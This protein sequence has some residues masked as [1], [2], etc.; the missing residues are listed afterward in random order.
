MVARSIMRL[1]PPRTITTGS[2]SFKSIELTGLSSVE[3][4]KIWGKDIAMV[5]QNP[6]TSL[7]PVFRIGSQITWTLRHHLG[8]NKD[9]AR[10][11]AVLLLERVGIPDA[12]RR[13]ESYPHE[14]SG[15][16]RQRVCIAIAIA[17]DPV[18]VLADEP[19]TALDVTIQRQILDLLEAISAENEMAMILISHDLGVIASRTSQLL[20]MYGGRIVEA[21]PTVEIFDNP[22]HPYTVA[23]LDAIPRV[24]SP[25]HSRLAAI[26]GAPVDLI[27]EPVGCHFASRCTYAQPRCHGE[28]PPLDSNPNDIQHAFACFYP[29]ELGGVTSTAGRLEP[30]R[31]QATPLSSGV[32]DEVVT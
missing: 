22:R 32:A 25:R 10:E 2:V 3:A 4:R 26:P 28:Q 16:M 30:G 18:L 1:T 31:H 7:N 14:L 11:R 29:V 6:M 21:G 24:D 13:L 23:L 5:L 12:A 27:G 17:C 20:I 15:G 8:L 9:S 19:T